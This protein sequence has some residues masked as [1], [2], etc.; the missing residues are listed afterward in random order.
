MKIKTQFRM[1]MFLFG[2]VLTAALAL[3]IAT[4]NQANRVT[5]QVAI[6]DSVALS[7]NELSYL[8]NDYLINRGDRQIARWRSSFVSLLN[9][10][11]GLS[12]DTPEEQMLVS[13]INENAGM[14]KETFDSVLA[15]VQNSP[16]DRSG[17]LN[18]DFLKISSSRLAVQTQGLF[19]DAHRLSRLTH[20]RA[21]TLRETRTTLVYG[22]LY[23]FVLFLLVNYTLNYRRTMRS[24]GKLQAGAKIIGAGSLDF[25]IKKERDDEIGELSD[26]FNQ[27][28]AG[29][30]T[31]TASK[32]DLEK[33]VE[34]RK[35]AEA[36]RSRLLAEVKAERDRLSALVASIR[37]EVW[38]ADTEKRFTLANPAALRE[39]G[40]N[41]DDAA[42]VERLAASLEV[43]RP[44]GSPRPVEEAPP[45]RALKGEIITNQEE[46]IRT[47]SSGELR[48]RQV[49]AAPVR[50]GQGNIIGSV[51]VAHDIT[52]RKKAEEALRESEERLRMALD[53]AF[54][55]SFEWNI[56]RNEVRRFVSA[57][58][59]LEATSK[60][61]PGSLEDVLKAVHPD[62]REIFK[63][64][65]YAAM[66]REDSAYESEFRLVRPNGETAWLYERGRVERDAEGRPS[67]LIG[68]S[69]DITR[70]K[71]AEEAV[72]QSQKTFAELIERSPFGTYVV[73][74]QFRIA[75]M[76]A[77]SQD[78]AF[79]NVRPIIG[80]DF[81]EA[82]CILWPEPVAVEII[83]HFRHTLDTGEPYYSPPFI[84]PRHDAEI[85]ESYEWELHR[86]TLPDGQ[87]GVICYY[88]DSTKLRKTEEALR[89]SEE[90]L[91]L[92]LTAANLGTWDYNPVTGAIVWD[93]RC[94]ELFGLPPEAEVDYDTFLASLH[95][96][97]RDRANEVVQHTFDPAGDGLFDIEY[98][99]VALRDGGMPRWIRATGR[100]SF[101]NAGQATRFTGTVQDITER[102]KAEAALRQ[103]L[104]EK[105]VLLKEIH[106]R[107]KN[108]MQVI[109]SMVSLQ[110]GELQ[111]PSTRDILD[112]V[113][114]RVRSMALVHEKLYQSADLSQID[115][116]GYAKSLL[117]YLWRAYGTADSDI[118]LAMDVEPVSLTVNTAVPC[119]LILNELVSNALKHAFRARKDGEVTVS[120]HSAQGMIRLS[121]RD[122]GTGLPEG[123]DWKQA[124]SLGLRLVRMLAGQLHAE[125]E[126]NSEDGTE[127]KI[128]F[129]QAE[130]GKDLKD[131][132]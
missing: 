104:A 40:L 118:R 75:M 17:G 96:E 1:I 132:S 33:E 41:T 105:E 8:S 37:D 127:F 34:E 72:K 11:K 50:D 108:N 10:V 116:A 53:A 63:A 74:S 100:A 24:I 89:Q 6:A 46:I 38:F 7:A 25:R 48:Y 93:A 13:N 119:G 56:K 20:A 54:L 31:A 102:K 66:E 69:Q 87:Y 76:N 113:T 92:A 12:V 83:G 115:F 29:L 58:P 51:S 101:N 23:L 64:N 95:P 26:A 15:V 52:E 45:L 125:V 107:V 123:F 110:A 97:D 42:D 59:A 79:R 81:A 114:H 130:S 86:M 99:T 14:L 85:V 36:D 103:S 94:K 27:M 47:P 2:S 22:L 131:E 80:R 55:I 117:G 39:F 19:S 61:K 71:R 67:R 68:L 28:T 43:L 82:M 9:Q 121:V 16:R 35:R 44:D 4:D 88:Y 98:R 5:R 18:S 106:H 77:S 111:D 57:E 126:L 78:G 112:E 73:D 128:T 90:R 120:I 21:D 65:V 62:D 70:R 124:H 84:N 32:N 3:A 60:D 91:R 30:K 109:S 129:R 122:D 49:S